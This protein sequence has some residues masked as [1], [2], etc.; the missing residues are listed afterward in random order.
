[1]RVGVYIDGFNLYYGASG[2]FGASE[3]GWKWLDV[4]ALANRRLFHVPGAHID[5][6][7][8]CTARVN[9]P[10]NVGQT[11]RQA[12]YLQALQS[13]GVVDVIEEGYYQSFAK[14]AVLT[15]EP[16]K[17]PKPTPYIDAAGTAQWSSGLRLRR[18]ADDGHVL[19]TVRKR[20]EKGSDVNVA[21]HLL[22][23]VLEKRVDAALVMSNDS[24]LALPVS[25]ARNHV[26]VGTINPGA[27][28]T[29][30]VLRGEA[31]DGVGGHF[32]GRLRRVDYLQSQ[33]PCQVG[34]LHKPAS[35]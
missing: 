7:V 23:D 24:D 10:D 4:R 33:L 28:P 12:V 25:I 19:A 30:G 26:P 16:P 15:N 17:T 8:Y 21:T 5:R 34:H 1:M 14:E 27:R 32:W 3:A 13:S 20:E 35:W 31:T 6:V 11:Q 29:A 2:Q 9:D 22:V 18:S